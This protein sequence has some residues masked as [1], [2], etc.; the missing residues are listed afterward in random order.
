MKYI[1]VILKTYAF[2]SDSI[3][4]KVKRTKRPIYGTINSEPI[5]LDE[6]GKDYVFTFV[7]QKFDLDEEEFL[8]LGAETLTNYSCVLKMNECQLDLLK[9][10]TGYL[11]WI[12]TKNISKKEMLKN[13]VIKKI[14]DVLN[15]I[16]NAEDILKAMGLGD[17]TLKQEL[18]GFINEVPME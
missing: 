15:E 14:I 11:G 8:D 16:G 6:N 13:E 18:Y 2:E 17:E 9:S 1:S 12:E 4:V 3:Q 5:I 10:L 7:C